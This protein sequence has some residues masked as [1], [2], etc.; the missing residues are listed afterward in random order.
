MGAW[1]GDSLSWRYAIEREARR[2][3][4][5]RLSAEVTRP[6]DQ[7]RLLRSIKTERLVYRLEELP[8][9]GR[10][11]PVA[12]EINFYR[13]PPYATYGLD[14]SEYPRVFADRGAVSKHRMLEDGALC[15]YFAHH[16]VSQRWSAADG[17]QRLIDLI[18]DHLFFEDYWKNN[19]EWL[20][21]EMKHGF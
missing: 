5:S 2:Y 1:F 19:G 18:S 9:R 21:P 14:P 13:M 16:P 4:G 3:W 8:V 7:G 6:E 11:N 10:V 20:A 17:L 15:L 12:I